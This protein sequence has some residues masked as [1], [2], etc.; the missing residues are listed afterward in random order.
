MD[1]GCK[2]KP[3]DNDINCHYLGI[4]LPSEKFCNSEKKPELYSSGTD[5][6]F[7]DNSFDFVNSY[8]VVPYVK[9]PD[10]LFS[11]IFRVLKKDG[12]AIIII[13]NLRGLALQPETHFENRY[14]SSDLH[15][16]LRKH[17]FKSIKWRNV[18]A[19]FFSTY[20]DLTSVYSYAI[21]TP[22]K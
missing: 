18:K 3:Y 16:K 2:F 9:N 13:M 20:F 22:K 19:L 12:V 11:E 6:P 4:D 5:L 8:S 15:K 7:R 14:S 10:K 17:S 1:I 21:V